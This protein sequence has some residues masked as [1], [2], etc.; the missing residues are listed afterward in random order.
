MERQASAPAPHTPF[1]ISQLNYDP[2]DEKVH[3]GGRALDAVI[4]PYATKTAGTPVS[5]KFTLSSRSFDYSF[6]SF[7]STCTNHTTEIY[8]PSFHYSDWNQFSVEVS[9]G[10]WHYD[11]IKQT[12]YWNIDPEMPVPAKS[13]WFPKSKIN[14]KVHSLKIFPVNFNI[15]RRWSL[16]WF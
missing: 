15:Q 13:I 5:M 14:E 10:T 8:V 2:P 12:I 3:L 4:R 16:L 7:K 9:D 11:A 1:D 6:S